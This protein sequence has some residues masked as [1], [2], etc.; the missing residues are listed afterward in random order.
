MKLIKKLGLTIP[1][2]FLVFA[3]TPNA[4]AQG[5]RDGQRYNV[6]QGQYQHSRV[7]PRERR[8]LLRQRARLYNTRSRIYRDG[9]VTNREANR[10]NRRA[11]RYRRNIYRARHN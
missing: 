2:L 6:Y 7:T 8:R 11:I 4:D 1:A 10:L 5:R 3:F 9:R